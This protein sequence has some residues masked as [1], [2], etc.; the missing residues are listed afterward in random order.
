[1]TQVK[2][3]NISSSIGALESRV[4][5]FL[6]KFA[7]KIVVKDVKYTADP[8]NGRSGRSATAMVIYETEELINLDISQPPT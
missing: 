3:F 6:S 8:S 1:M 4:N 2:F 7:N 5:D